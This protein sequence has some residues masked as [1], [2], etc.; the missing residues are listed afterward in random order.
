MPKTLSVVG[1]SAVGAGFVTVIGGAALAVANDRKSGYSSDL[2]VGPFFM[3]EAGAL[4][5]VVGGVCL[6]VALPF[7]L[8]GLNRLKWVAED[9][10]QKGGHATEINLGLQKNGFGIAMNF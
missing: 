8:I 4:A 9:Y 10:N 1:A 7:G 2:P 5:M 3:M 6:D